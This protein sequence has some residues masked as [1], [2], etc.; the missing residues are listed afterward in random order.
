MTTTIEIRDDQ[1][2]ELNAYKEKGDSFKDVIDKV[3]A[4]EPVDTPDLEC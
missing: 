2:E 4:T 1:W 3:L